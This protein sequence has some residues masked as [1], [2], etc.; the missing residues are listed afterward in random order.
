MRPMR[1]AV[2]MCVG[3]V[4]LVLACAPART[5]LGQQADAEQRAD[6]PSAG[7]TRSTPSRPDGDPADRRVLLASDLEGLA[8]RSIGPANMG[9]R[10]AALAFEP[11]NSKTFYVGYATG[12][13]W[14]TTNNGT[15][16]SPLFD[17]Q[18]T[19]SIGS[20]A[21]AD[22]PPDWPGWDDEDEPVAREERAEKGRG[23]IVW[24][25]T[26]EGNGRNS[27]SWGHGV[28]RSTDHGKTWR[29]LGL[30]D[31]HDIPAIAVDPRDPDVCYVAALGHLWGP[32]QTRGIYKTVDGGETWDAVLQVDE[33]TG[34]CDVVID[35]SD[36]DTVYA[37]MYTRR[38]S[39][40]SF[41]S[42]SE[43]GGIF[44]SDDAG[45]T[46]TR[47]ENGLPDQTGRIGLAVFPKDSNVIMAT[48]ES[49]EQG[50]FA[51]TWT[52]FS[53][54]G[55]VY[56]SEDRGDTWVRTSDFTPRSFYFSTIAIDPVDS[57]RVYLLGWH[58]YVSDDGGRT[59]RSGFSNVVH[60]DHHAMIIDPEDPDHLVI[61]N[62]GGVYVSWD[63]GKTW[64]FQNH[65]AVGQF[66]NVAVDDSDP[67]RVGGG[68]QDNGSWIGPSESLHRADGDFMGRKGAIWNGDWTF[69]YGG[70]GFHVLFDPT[71]EHVIY[72]EWQG[73]NIAR[74]HLD[75]GE[76]FNLKP[77]P[78]EGEPR[79][80]FN[81][82]APIVISPH[83]PTTLY[84]AGNHVFRMPQRGDVWERISPDLSRA[85]PELITA[86][87]SEAE[88]AGTVTALDESPLAEGLL[89]AGTDDGR[90]HVTEN[91]G[92]SW[93]EVTPRDVEGYYFQQVVASA[94]DRDTA[95]AAVSGHRSDVFEPFILVTED[96]GATWRRI[97]RAG[98]EGGLPVGWPPRTVIEDPRNPEVL[99]AGTEQGVWVTVDRGSGA[100]GGWMKLADESLPNVRTDELAMQAREMDLVAGTHGRSIWILDDVSPISQLTA[101]VMERA[102]HVF[103]TMP[104]RPR[105]YLSA[106]GLWSDAMFV[107]PN[108]PM[109]AYVHYWIGEY[110]P[111]EVKLTV[112][113]AAG[114]VVRELTGP[115]RPGINRVV[116]DLQADE[117]QRLGDPHGMTE[118]VPAGEYT[119]ELSYGDLT[120]TTT[121]EVLPEPGE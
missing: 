113:N 74:V 111:E 97:D 4:G 80:R 71:D 90:L 101:E 116:W 18:A 91:G 46:W 104:G 63:R 82:N 34:A 84:F 85:D 50:K 69:V 93:R 38:R 114:A 39:I 70:D 121:V 65:M 30:A 31:A 28:Y 45:R 47:L 103:G 22:A 79:F 100:L 117:K 35:P 10:V 41:V 102:F 44:R 56:R 107:A 64:D 62:D 77:A 5:S 89:W 13:V 17:D 105:H 73:G 112:K 72:A 32:N 51:D 53:R 25:G 2:V 118:F 106:G 42:G 98:E 120:G 40:G 67:Y 88:T 26:G 54:T 109:G 29:H 16:F 7:E 94:H 52:N 8:W 59:F 27:S 55:G 76:T 12:G 95:Y 119:I 99:Y 87:G 20:I 66:Y 57:R 15:T 37:A 43:T 24:V 78:K 115:N 33:D 96:L 110:A 36:P 6:R 14:K 68:L 23:K 19:L 3:L 61:G 75:T 49:D 9:G 1:V 11:G 86:V 21:V 48:V 81:W 92:G 60:V 58:V 83:D 108:P